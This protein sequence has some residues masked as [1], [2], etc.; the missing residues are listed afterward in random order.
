MITREKSLYWWLLGALIS[1]VVLI[2]F[3]GPILSPFL[4]AGILAYICDPLVDK[5]EVRRFSRTGGT[6]LVL[7]F[8]TGLIALLLVILIPLISKE[9]T[10]LMERLPGVINQLSESVEPWLRKHLGTG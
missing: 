4:L 6:V 2:Y 9:V 7:T 8:L 1:T 10:I 3:L 5:L